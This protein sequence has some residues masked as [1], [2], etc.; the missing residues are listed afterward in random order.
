[1]QRFKKILLV[2]GDSPNR[3]AGVARAETL[4][5]RNRAQL[6]AVAAF[7]DFPR[8]LKLLK[9]MDPQELKARITQEIQ[10]ELEERLTWVSQRGLPTSGKV[11]W[12]T[13][14]LEIIREVLRENHDLV[15][16]TPERDR[17]SKWLGSTATHLLRKCP[18][19]V[20]VLKQ[21]VRKPFRRILAAVEPDSFDETKAALCTKVM[22]LATSLSQME[23]AELHVV[24]SWYPTV[25]PM[26]R[27]RIRVSGGAVDRFLRE[28]REI[29]AKWL[30]DVVDRFQRDGFEMQVHLVSGDAAKVIAGMSKRLHIDAIVMGTVGRIGIEGFFIGNTAENVLQE[31]D[32]SLLAVK[33]DGFVS[34]VKL[35][36]SHK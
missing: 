31:I 14:F 36:Q 29:H 13:P 11:L 30:Q 3:E 33:P 21:N 32:C 23:G 5:V 18:C 1:M 19:P 8:E 15:V 17:N 25:A 2:V 6:T 27:N 20:W 10:K 9:G 16:L 24:H 26:L 28:T 7:A 12:G 34:P 22:E 4:A 35:E